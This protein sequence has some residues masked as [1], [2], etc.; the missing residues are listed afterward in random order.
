M[1]PIGNVTNEKYNEQNKRLK[2]LD[3]FKNRMKV[4][5]EKVSEVEYEWRYYTIRKTERTEEKK[6]ANSEIDDIIYNVSKTCHWSYRKKGERVWCLNKY[7][8][9]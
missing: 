3:G 9:K 4:G 1:K 5:E 2:W 6:L 8:K 7:L